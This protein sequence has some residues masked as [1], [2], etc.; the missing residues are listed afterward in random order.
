M[1][2]IQDEFV[3]SVSDALK[4]RLAPDAGVRTGR[5]AVDAEAYRRYLVARS[6]LQERGLENTQ[7]AVRLFDEAATIDPSFAGAHA[8]KALALTLLYF[9][10]GVGDGRTMFADA[11]A[12]ARRALELDPR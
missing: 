12:G 8:G 6:R 7:A 2:D 10:H 4:I 3:G 11:D 5:P 9:N 1:L